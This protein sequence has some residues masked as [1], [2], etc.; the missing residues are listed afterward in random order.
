MRLIRLGEA[1]TLTALALPHLAEGAVAAAAAAPPPQFELNLLSAYPRAKCLDGSPGAY[2]SYRQENVDKWIVYIEGGA[3]CFTPT[4]CAGRALTSLG[5]ST[6]YIKSFARDKGHG[7]N[8]VLIGGITSANCTVNPTFCR[9]NVAF[10]KYCD[11]ASFSGSNS[12]VGPDGLHYRGFDTLTAILTDLK[13]KHS[14]SDATEVLLT[15]GSAG[16]MSVR[17]LNTT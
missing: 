9:H 4:G 12:E 15:G 3:W 8:P 17:A 16:G 2:Y 13:A 1:L 11:G 7:G 10:I 5:S 14:I 6:S